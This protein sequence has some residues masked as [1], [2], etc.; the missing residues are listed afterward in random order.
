MEIHP[1]PATF[2][3]FIHGFNMGD[4]LCDHVDAGNDKESPDKIVQGKP[5]KL[6]Q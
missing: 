1:E 3:E 5:H 2:D 4:I 6:R